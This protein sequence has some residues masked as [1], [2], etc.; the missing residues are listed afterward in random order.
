MKAKNMLKVLLLITVLV[1][2]AAPSWAQKMLDIGITTPLTGPIANLGT[3]FKNGALMAIEDANARGGVTIAGVK[4]KLNPIIRDDKF[5]PATG[6]AVAEELVFDKKVKVIIGPSMIEGPSMLQ[7]T[8]PNKVIMF[9]MSPVPYMCGPQRPY[10]FFVGGMMEQ[11]Y[12]TVIEYTKKYYPNLKKVLTLY[13]DLSDAP[14]WTGAGKMMFTKNGFT[15]LGVE[16]YPRDTT[17]YGPIVQKV[18]SHKPEIVDFSG[19]GGAMGAMCGLITKQLR[20]GGFK[21]IIIMPTSP[22][23]GI[24]ETIP[25]EYLTNIVTNDINVDSPVVTKEYRDLYKRYVKNYGSKPI[26][27]TAQAYNG[28]NAFFK[29]LDGQK[30][31]DTTEWVKG[32]EKYKWTGIMGDKA[33]WIGSAQFGINRGLVTNVWVSEWKNGK[34][35]TNFTAK[36]DYAMF[37]KK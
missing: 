12:S 34:L 33:R 27:M 10:N 3:N 8:E 2:F 32:F 28:V 4:Y 23:P 22:P 20:Q 17:D 6:K 19:S 35:E 30:T 21:G 11:M 9:A 18:M 13:A 37:E 25:K 36:I 14:P 15:Y 16:L 29:F 1:C 7:I 31:M 5:D 24:M 26:D